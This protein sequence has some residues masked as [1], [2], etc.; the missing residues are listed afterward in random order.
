MGGSCRPPALHGARRRVCRLYFGMGLWYL[1]FPDRA[2]ERSRRGSPSATV[3]RTPSSLAL[4]LSFA[5]GSTQSCDASSLRREVEPRRQSTS[6][7]SIACHSGSPLEPCARALLWSASVNRRR[8]SLNFAPALP[9]GTAICARVLDTQWLGFIAEAHLQAGQLDDALAALD[10]AAETAAATGECYYQ[11]EL[12]RLR[13]VVLA[14]TGEAGRSGI[15]A[16][17]GDRYRP[18]P[19]GEIAGA[20]R[21]DQPRPA[22]GRAGQA[23][24]GP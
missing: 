4:A 18:Q 21:R 24:R 23:C 7:A 22:M 2:W 12:Y 8:G 13:G 5:A 16:P 15:M 11:A 19:A 17:A 9:A 20:A 1:G 10:R 3:S 6:R 14:Q